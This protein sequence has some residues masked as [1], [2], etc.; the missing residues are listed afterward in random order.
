[1]KNEREILEKK[2]LEKYN[3]LNA[4]QKL[5]VDT[6]EGPVL[7]IAGPGTGK[8]ELLSMRAANIL[9]TTDAIP[10]SILCLTFTEAGAT[11]MKKRIINLTGKDG[12]K[13]FV[14]TFHSFCNYIIERFPKYFFEEVEFSMAS[15]LDKIN[16]LKEILDDLPHNHIYAKKFSGGYLYQNDI[17]KKISKIKNSRYSLNGEFKNKILELEKE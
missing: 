12:Y 8:T 2:F 9:R 14:S 15:D 11:E 7:V 3:K 16:I 1:M 10:S 6:V 4:A 13:V 5:A 17:F